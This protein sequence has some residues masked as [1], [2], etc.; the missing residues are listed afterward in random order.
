MCG[1]TTIN[2]GREVKLYTP[3]STLYYYIDDD[4]LYIGRWVYKKYMPLDPKRQKIVGVE[5]FLENY[6]KVLDKL[7]SV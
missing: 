4:A 3:T 7:V 1:W 5:K 6:K 2:N